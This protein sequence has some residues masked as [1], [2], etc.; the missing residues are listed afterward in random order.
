MKSGRGS[1]HAEPVEALGGVFQQPAR[2]RLADNRVRPAAALR[3]SMGE[4]AEPTQ[5][6]RDRV[7]RLTDACGG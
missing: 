7:F 4:R 1:A 5:R 6:T 2:G 3:A